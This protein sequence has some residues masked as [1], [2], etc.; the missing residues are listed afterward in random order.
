MTAF[1]VHSHNLRGSIKASTLDWIV[2]TIG[3]KQ[4][5]CTAILLQDIGRTD[6]EGPSILRNHKGLEGHTIYANSSMN[7]K[8]KS[9]VIIV[10]KN[11]QVHKVLRDKSGSLVGV[12]A[13]RGSLEILVSAYLPTNLDLCGCPLEWDLQKPS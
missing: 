11:W 2:N 4:C 8:S 7:N 10:H 3:N 6:P 9:V 13:S 1:Q 5:E 12:V